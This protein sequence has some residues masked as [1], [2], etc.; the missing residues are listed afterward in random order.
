[1]TYCEFCESKFN[2][3]ELANC[4]ECNAS[5]H[6]KCLNDKQVCPYCVNNDK[7]SINDAIKVL[8]KRTSKIDS[9]ESQLN[10]IL[11]IKEEVKE[12]KVKIEKLE[13][14]TKK[15]K[16]EL[17]Q[18]KQYSRMNNLEIIGVPTTEA[19]N[20]NDIVFTI[21]NIIGYHITNA[22]VVL[23]HR[24]KSFNKVNTPNVVCVMRDRNIKNKFLEA[25]KEHTKT[26]KT[27]I[28]AYNLSP[29]FQ[30][31]PIFVNEHLSPENKQILREAKKLKTE[32]NWKYV[33]VKD[34]KV[35][36]RQSE[37]TKAVWFTDIEEVLLLLK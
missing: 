12:H 32:K 7:I 3:R 17:S 14:T 29:R 5:V 28:K 20:T 8:L 34:G 36:A 19:E 10:Q 37:E 25:Y 4:V 2:G 15:L 9:I 11:E 22:D 16:M 31:T 24:V 33:W 26:M 13:E 30:K 6:T 23:S 18:V 1:M 27:S 21:A 35:H